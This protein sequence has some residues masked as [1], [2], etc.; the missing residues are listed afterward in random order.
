M[1]ENFI[2]A[3]FISSLKEFGTTGRYQI[4]RRLGQGGAGVVYLGRDHYIKRDIAIKISQPSSDRARERFLVEAQSA[5]RLHHPNIVA[6][7]DAGVCR[8]YCYITMEYVD[9][10]PLEKFCRKES[11]L[12][13]K[14]GLRIILDVCNAL[15]YAHK[16]GVIHR[17]IKPSNIIL[18]KTDTPK[19][20][21]FSIAQM[22]ERTAPVGIFGTPSYMSPEQLKDEALGTQSDIFSV[23]CVLY[24]LL[25]GERTFSGD[26]SF[27]I[28]YKTINEKPKSILSIRP[29]LPKILQE[30]TKKALAKNPKKRYQ[31]CMDLGCDLSVAFRGLTGEIKKEKK[32]DDAV[33]FV[34]NLRFFRDFT[35][36][37]VKELM[38]ASHI[39][40]VGEGKVIM[41]EGEIDD[42]FYVILSGKVKVMKNDKPIALID[43]G[44][45]FG[46][47]AYIGGQPRAANVV[48]ETDCILMKI[49]APLLDRAS[50]AMQ[51]LFFKNFAMTLVQRLSNVDQK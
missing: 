34:H 17:D 8:D 35:R 16:E 48:T 28:M 10:P 40:K 4:I 33:G 2:E 19:I 36:D 15:D 12:P 39:V 41:S 7:Y 26:N 23:G 51:L 42:T 21:D 30:I 38:S 11:L 37:Q 50:E 1:A 27:S 20:T 31:T 46:E 29:D 25:T 9:G 47:M 43:V 3:G 22:I 5:G 45:C 13:L 44:K 18:D 32:I 6:V 24:E 14:K 49:S